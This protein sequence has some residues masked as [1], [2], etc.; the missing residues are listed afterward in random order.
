MYSMQHMFRL[1]DPFIYNCLDAFG[2]AGCSGNIV[3]ARVGSRCLLI[4]TRFP[5]KQNASLVIQFFPGLPLFI[6]D[7]AAIRPSVIMPA[8]CFVAYF[9]FT[10][11]FD[12][13]MLHLLVTTACPTSASPVPPCRVQQWHAVGRGWLHSHA[14]LQIT[15]TLTANV[16]VTPNEPIL[17]RRPLPT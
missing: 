11:R 5:F 6:P 4:I 7:L 10:S 16:F 13:A 17:T 12:R 1:S 2:S 9:H 14:R 8:G 3:I 15:W